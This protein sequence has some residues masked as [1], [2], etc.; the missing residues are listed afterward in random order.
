MKILADKV[1]LMLLCIII[2]S[3]DGRTSVPVIV[4]LISVCAS[5]AAQLMSEKKQHGEIVL[6]GCS[7]MCIFVPEFVYAAPLMIYDG[8][9][10]KKWWLCIPCAGAAF[11]LSQF[12]TTQICLIIAGGYM[13]AVLAMR[14]KAV[15][16]LSGKLHDIRDTAAEKNAA[17]EL[18]NKRLAEVQDNEIYL[19]TLNE[20]N[21][22]ARE[23][24]DNVGHMLTRSILQA[25]A[26]K[27]INKDKELDE[28]IESLKE[29]LDTAMTS[30]RRSVHDLHDDSIDLEQSVREC[31]KTADTGFD[32]NLDYDMGDSRSVPKDIKLCMIGIVK[33]GLSNIVRHSKGDSVK[34]VIREH[35]AFYQLAVED[36]GECSSGLADMLEN[37]SVACGIGIANMKER[38]KSVNGLIRFSAGEN[39]FRIF[40]SAPKQI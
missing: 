23:I 33:E 4:L 21:R 9:Y 31:I 25:G 29:T 11:S 24:H 13:A 1:A 38:V 26:L 27:I 6:L 10:C 8:V 35:P 22:I 18:K 2:S 37:D 39:G 15:N 32:V 36:N 5:A 7:V 19:A 40:M 34:I 16:I 14:T 3:L 20:R 17:L 28:P 12:S 30:I